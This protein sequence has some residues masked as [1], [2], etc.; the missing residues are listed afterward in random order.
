MFTMIEGEGAIVYLTTKVGG[1]A[2]MGKTQLF[3][4][5]LILTEK[6]LSCLHW[7]SFVIIC[8]AV[9]VSDQHPRV[10]KARPKHVT[11]N[12]M[13]AFSSQGGYFSGDFFLGVFFSKIGWVFFPRVFFLKRFYG[14]CTILEYIS[15][16]N[17]YKSYQKT[18]HIKN[19]TRFQRINSRNF[20]HNDLCLQFA[21]NDVINDFK[22]HFQTLL[23]KFRGAFKE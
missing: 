7:T 3:D 19:S 4:P 17:S 5:S 12:Q 11:N 10:G 23:S 14:S 2:I 6:K 16:S 1:G 22:S 13:C 20:S 21:Q 18:W 9:T 8:S 15:S